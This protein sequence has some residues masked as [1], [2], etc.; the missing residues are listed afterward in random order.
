MCVTG[1][2]MGDTTTQSCRCWHSGQTVRWGGRRTGEA[3]TARFDPLTARGSCSASEEPQS[4]LQEEGWT[5]TSQCR[6]CRWNRRGKS[7]TP[8]SYAAFLLK[9]KMRHIKCGSPCARSHPRDWRTGC[10]VPIAHRARLT[11]QRRSAVRG[12]IR[13]SPSTGHHRRTHTSPP[14]RLCSGG[15]SPYSGTC[16]H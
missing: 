3:Q 15:F 1:D 14:S 5:C 10:V 12:T 8:C 2:A 11:A 7:S 9:R 4:A 13:P 6:S 16:S